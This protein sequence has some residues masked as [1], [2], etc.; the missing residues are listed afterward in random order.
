MLAR[1]MLPVVPLVMLALDFD[2]VAARA[3]IGN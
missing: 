1:Y 2:A 3:T